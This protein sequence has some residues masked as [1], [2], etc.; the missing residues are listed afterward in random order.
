MKKDEIKLKGTKDGVEVYLDTRVDAEELIQDL[1][2]FL[3]EKQDFFAG[4]K[5]DVFRIIGNHF[6]E[7]QK[8]K[9]ASVAQARVACGT[10]DF[11]SMD[12]FRSH[13][14]DEKKNA[15]RSRRRAASAVQEA[16]PSESG[17]AAHKFKDVPTRYVEGTIRSGDSVSFDGNIVVLG[18]VNAGAEIQASGSVFVLGTLRGTAHAGCQGDENAFIYALC[19]IPLQIRIAHIIAK[20]PDGK[21]KVLLRPE[22]ARIYEDCIS[23][24]PAANL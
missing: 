21:Q 12:D 16:Q 3:A 24:E 11:M 5:I 4:T 8:Q 2:A 17:K 18:D 20:A 7:E 22:I 23:I 14:F 6:S 13:R 15:P 10:I 9:L 1:D 19:M